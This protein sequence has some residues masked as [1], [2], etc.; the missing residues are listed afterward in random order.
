MKDPYIVLGLGKDAGAEALAARYEQLKATL[1]EARFLPGKEGNDAAEKLS[2]LEEAWANIRVDI[3]MQAGSGQDGGEYI[4]IDNL[5]KAGRYDEAQKM[6]DSVS[7]RSAEWYYLQSIIFYKREWIADSLKQL[8][9]AVSL[10]PYSQKYRTA[11]DRMKMINGNPKVEP[12]S[13]GGNQNTSQQYSTENTAARTCSNCCWAYICTDC[14]C[15]LL[16]CC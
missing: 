14:L 8:E 5:I 4:Y 13:L 2:E 1:S 12:T 9:L 6:L 10:D 15:S 11:L 3:Q 16:R 7:A